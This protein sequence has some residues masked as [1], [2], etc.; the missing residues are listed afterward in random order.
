MLLKD[1]DGKALAKMLDAPELVAEVE[2]AV[3]QVQQ[4]LDQKK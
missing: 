3:H 2:R 4:Q 1:T